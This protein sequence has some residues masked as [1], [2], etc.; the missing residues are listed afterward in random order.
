MMCTPVNNL[1][2]KII[3]LLQRNRG[4]HALHMNGTRS[5]FVLLCSE[6]AFS[7]NVPTRT[8]H[9]LTHQDWIVPFFLFLN[10]KE[11]FTTNFKKGILHLSLFFEALMVMLKWCWLSEI[12][13]VSDIFSLLC[14]LFY[15]CGVFFR[16]SIRFGSSLLYF[17]PS[18]I[19][20]YVLL[21]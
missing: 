19:W 20:T 7:N 8:D 14:F 12:K 5:S 21:I 4:G 16:R 2:H 10:K 1:K 18:H 13:I 17:L 6:S 11:P 9:S 3:M 15:V